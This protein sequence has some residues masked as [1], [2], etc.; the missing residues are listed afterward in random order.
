MQ[1]TPT[2]FIVLGLVERA[3]EATPY[4]LK[5]IAE[6]SV[7]NFWSVPHSQLYAEPVRLAKAGFLSER[8]ERGGRRRRHYAI[9]KPGREAL[10]A[11]RDEPTETLPELR[12]LSLL[13]LFFGGDPEVLAPPQRRAHERQLAFYRDLLAAYS[14]GDPPG[15]PRTLRAGI[16]HG[17]EWV[18]YWSELAG[19]PPGDG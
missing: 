14:E 11:W 10:A 1:L 13:K 5:R 7:G 8:R 16:G 2:S 17:E 12:D 4:E 3:G 18:R 9:A 6:G 15:P 19:D